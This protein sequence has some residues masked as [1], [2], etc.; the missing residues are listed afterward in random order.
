MPVANPHPAHTTALT[1]LRHSVV[2]PWESIDQVISQ[3]ASANL[4]DP[5][6]PGTAHWHLR[7]IVEIFQLHAA[8]MRSESPPDPALLPT[9]PRALRDQLLT[10]INALDEWL[11]Q[12]DH[13]F[14]TRPI[15]YGSPHTFLEMVSI[16]LQH[17]TWHAAAVHYWVKFSQR[18]RVD[19]H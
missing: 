16:M 15:H 18:W 11:A 9:D 1:L 19:P 14:F 12:Q 6:T 17:I 10:D 7:H 8:T 2:L 3:H 5:H 4:G 13:A